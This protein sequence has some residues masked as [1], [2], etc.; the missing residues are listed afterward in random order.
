VTDHD[1][2]TIS[3]GSPAWSATAERTESGLRLLAD[4]LA[5]WTAEYPDVHATTE[6]LPVSPA[7]ALT[8]ASEHASPMLKSKIGRG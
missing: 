4:A 6:A 7:T 2:A 8:D 3:T 5:S 1:P